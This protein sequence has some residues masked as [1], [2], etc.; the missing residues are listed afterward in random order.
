M[1]D[2]ERSERADMQAGAVVPLDLGLS[3]ADVVPDV[4]EAV[5][6]GE[7][8]WLPAATVNMSRTAYG[9]CALVTTS[10]F[11]TVFTSPCGPFS[12]SATT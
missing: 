2:R 12:A 8:R 5:P 9:R 11:V 4:E 10:F 3:V 6:D 1:L 7:P